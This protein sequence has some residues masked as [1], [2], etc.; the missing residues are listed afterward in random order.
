[1]TEDEIERLRPIVERQARS[2]ADG[3]PGI[4]PDDV[5]GAAWLALC[6]AADKV[7]EE[8]DNY[9][10]SIAWN[11]GRRYAGAEL[12][13]YQH[14]SAA[15]VYTPREVRALLKVAWSEPGLWEKAPKRDDRE[16]LT[17]GGIVVALWDLDNAIQ[18]LS[19]DAQ[20]VLLRAYEQGETLGTA[21]RKRVSRAVE[22]I[23]R[24][25][26]QRTPRAG[27]DPRRGHNGPG[28][29]RAVTNAAATAATDL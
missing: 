18:T 17:A 12:Y 8:D 23:T 6:E 3:H 27:R 11:A 10:A 13:A 20:I 16:S 15:W 19:T 21:D 28:A 25:L 1:M 4:D 22:Q 7:R 9:A 5:A 14:F 24:Y 29:R 2:L 26:N